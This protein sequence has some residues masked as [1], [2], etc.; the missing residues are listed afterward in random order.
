MSD[1]RASQLENM[2]KTQRPLVI[3]WIGVILYTA[4]FTT[5]SWMRYEAFSYNDFDF[6]L[7]VHECW[8]ALHGS[9]RISLFLNVPIWGNA[10]EFISIVT[11]PFLLLSGYHPQGLLFFQSLALGASAVPIYLI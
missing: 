9:A 2:W 4:F 3:V 10:L 11:S 7:F 1:P 6:A 8:K 5:L